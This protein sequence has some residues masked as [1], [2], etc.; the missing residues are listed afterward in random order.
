[1][2]FL[3]FCLCLISILIFGFYLFSQEPFKYDP[4]GKRDPFSALVDKEGNLLP[5]ARPVDSAVELN[6]EGILW[7]GKGD[8]YA[9]INGTVLKGGDLLGD[10]KVIKIEEKKVI[11][12]RGEEEISINLSSE[13][14]SY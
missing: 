2:K 4:H 3:I 13:E 8:S 1:M 14:E 10:Y 5:E 12:S 6:L 7:D 11:L 9:I